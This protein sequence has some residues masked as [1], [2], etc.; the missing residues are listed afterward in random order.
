[1]KP[2]LLL[3]DEPTGNLDS[4]NSQT[5][6]ELFFNLNARHGT[7]MVIVTHNEMLA[8]SV[9]RVV[10]MRDG[11]IVEDTL[12]SSIVHPA[13]ADLPADSSASESDAAP[14]PSTDPAD[15]NSPATT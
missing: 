8:A 15:T 5:M 13:S 11:I 14:A 12:A 4:A 3:A 2:K 6:H 1:L 9:P 7:T 10:K